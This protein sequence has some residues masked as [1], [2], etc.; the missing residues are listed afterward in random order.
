MR[1]SGRS[2]ADGPARRACRPAPVCLVLAGLLA[3]GAA[4]DAAGDEVPATAMGEC[5][6]TVGEGD[7]I[8][9]CL[10]AM[11]ARVAEA[12]QRTADRAA[13]YFAD[14][15]TITGGER[16]SLTL[17]HGQAAFA[18]YRDLDCQLVEV[19]HGV[20]RAAADHRRACRIDH[21]RARIAKLAALLPAAA[22]TEA[23][24]APAAQ[25]GAAMMLG[26]AWRVVAIDGEPLA[27]GVEITLEVDETGGFA[28]QGGC[29]RYFG[30][31]EITAE[32]VAFGR[33]AATRMACPEPAMGEEQRYFAALEAVAVW[34]LEGE[35]LGLA[36]E[37]GT[38]RVSLEPKAG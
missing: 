15:D 31:A 18:L 11:E 20:G 32:R 5:L 14:L 12:L 10:E 9:R 7:A 33:P 37:H 29:N 6:A 8:G 28:G 4:G 27:D 26:S 34:Q 30:T 21:D 2:S 38:V 22:A 23:S 35:R 17:A 3:M 16:A 19:A 1:S 36:D 25:P 24:D 13:A